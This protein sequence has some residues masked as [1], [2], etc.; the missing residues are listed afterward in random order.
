M[1]AHPV[2]FGID[3]G[4][5]KIEG[6]AFDDQLRALFRERQP[7]VANLGYDSML[8]QIKR[9]Y[10]FLCEKTG[11]HDAP[12]GVGAPG[13]PS[14]ASGLWR[15]SNALCLNGRALKTDLQK[16][17]GRSFVLEN[18]ANCFALAE[19]RLGAAARHR[20]VFGIILGSGCGGG[21]IWDH[22]IHAGRNHI[23]GEWGHT[24]LDPSGPLCYC[25][26]RGCAELYVSGTGMERYYLE[27]TGQSLR[28]PRILEQSKGGQ[29]EARKVTDRFFEFLGIGVSNGI[30]TLDP[31]VIVF[32]GGLSQWPELYTR[33]AAEIQRRVFGGHCDTPL[34]PNKLGDSAG[35]LGAA[36][37]GQA[38]IEIETAK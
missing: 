6:A 3:I 31:D 34:L 36:L 4:G 13:S 29:S 33:G 26:K 38:A 22:T 35:V 27:L 8:R 24:V 14:P 10:D 23:G 32:G 25:G 16:L 37:L 18:D 19:A 7:A 30:N 2:R 1:G 28:V 11:R 9:V 15:N 12:L 17:L 5:T 21:L 20:L